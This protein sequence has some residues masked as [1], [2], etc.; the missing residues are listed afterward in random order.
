[1][2]RPELADDLPVVTANRSSFNSHPEPAPQ[3]SDA[4]AGVDDGPR[5]LLIRTERDEG[6]RVRLTVQMSRW[7]RAHVVDKLF[8]PFTRLRVSG[9]GIGLSRQ[10]SIIESM[11]VVCGRT[12]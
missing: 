4:M 10:R 5:Q 9:M 2:L 3:W 11:V 1:M 12:E 6:D 8:Q 7:P